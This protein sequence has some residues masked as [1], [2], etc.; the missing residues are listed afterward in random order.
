[1]EREGLSWLHMECHWI[2]LDR[3]LIVRVAPYS[4]AEVR[5]IV[6][7]RAA[8]EHCAVTTDALDGLADAA[9]HGGSL[10]HALALLGAARVLACSE[11]EDGVEDG[12]EAMTT[13]SGCLQL[14]M[15]H[16]SRMFVHSSSMLARVQ[17]V[18]NAVNAS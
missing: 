2:L 11:N 8:A 7:Q 1:M 16:I 5:R 3:L 14:L 4:A 6:E 12:G 15:H 13:Q 18:S 9:A 10:R 17:S